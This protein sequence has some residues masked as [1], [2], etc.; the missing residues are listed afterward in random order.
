MDPVYFVMAILGC[1]DDGLSCRQ[2]RVEPVR[3]ESAAQCNASMDR[4]LPRHADLDYPVIG[5]S[6][7]AQGGRLADTRPP[8]R[9]DS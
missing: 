3:Y 2:A 6:C 8:V 9:T 1:G 5:A 7:Q 4:I